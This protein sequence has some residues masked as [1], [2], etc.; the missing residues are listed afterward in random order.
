MDAGK[1]LADGHPV[2]RPQAR[3]WAAATAKT[4]LG[5]ALISF[6]A[7]RPPETNTL[8]DGW[9]GMMGIVL[10]LHFGLFHT[11]SLIWRTAGVDAQPI[12]RSPASSTSLSEFWGKRW[13]LGFRQLTHSLIYEPVRRKAGPSHAILAAFAVSGIIHDLVIS[14]PARGGY[15]LPTVY[16]LLQGIGVLLEKSKAGRWLGIGGGIRGRIFV[17]FCAGAPALLLFHPPFINNVM[18]PFFAFLGTI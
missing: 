5:I 12:M 16:F 3:E 7:H 4:L 6:V 13:N 14:F 10:L 17:S 8:L 15:G 2:A 9:I 1:F 18:L 11:I